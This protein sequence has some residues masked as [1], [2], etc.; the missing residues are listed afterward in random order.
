MSEPEA[1][2]KTRR[3]LRFGTQLVLLLAGFVL[4]L[5][6]L[7]WLAVEVAVERSVAGQL[8]NKLH[9]GA[10]VWSQLHE[11]RQQQLLERVVVLAEDFGFREAVALQ[12][13]PTLGSVLESASTRLGAPYGAILDPGGRVLAQRLPPGGTLAADGLARSLAT[14]REAGFASGVVRFGSDVSRYALV[15]VFAPDLVG[16]LA[17]GQPLDAAEITDFAT[18]TGLVPGLLV[19]EDGGWRS[20]HGDWQP[21]AAAAALLARGEA[22]LFLPGADG[23]PSRKALRLSAAG[24]PAVYLVLKADRARAL[25]PYADLQAQLLALSLLAALLAMLAALLLGHRVSAPVDQLAEAARRVRAGDYAAPLAV[26]GSNEFAALA[27]AFNAM[28]QG[29]AEREQRIVHQAGHDG[30]TGLPNRERA[31]ALL[32]QRLEDPGLRQGA[33]ALLDL[34][35]FRE[36]N[37]LLGHAHGDRALVGLAERLRGLRSGDD[38]VARLGGDE[39]LVGFWGSDAAQAMAR[40]EALVVALSAPMDLDGAPL[41]VDI[42]LGLVPFIRGSNGPLPDAR[43]LLR[44]AEIALALAKREG[45]SPMPYRQGLDER[46]LRQLAIVGELRGAIESEQFQLAYQPKIELGDGRVQHVEA[47]LRWTH[48]QLGRIGPDEFIPLA[49]RAGLVGRLTRWVAARA[50]ADL[51]GWRAQGVEVGVAINLS[52]IDLA[53]PGLGAMLLDAAAHHGVPAGLL[54]AEVTE[55][56]VLADLGTAVATLQGL[57]VQG[58]RVSIDDFGTGQSSLAQLKRLPADE[59]KIDKSFVLPLAPGSDDEH[60]VESIVRLGHALGLRVVAEGVETA[61]GLGVLRRLGCDVAQGYHFSRPLA[62]EALL[63]WLRAHA[64]GP[65]GAAA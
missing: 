50:C 9:V 29:I 64:T 39:F 58:L 54:I 42:D 12:D 49:E 2:A 16:W 59:L 57:R 55:S 63:P 20:L 37:D 31:L 34:R 46:H 3:G 56:A 28:Q 62:V 18:I 30:L 22:L 60:I 10:R 44:R 7:G 43:T 27:A 19:A 24:A 17:I 65:A 47:L 1:P 6:G 5:Q 51:A 35:R 52:A 13:G 32:G 41:R 48:P 40:A 36:V 15:P 45:R 61:E 53:D 4:A 11:G 33:L 8:E 26:G 14:A 23:E 25:A 38:L 21:D